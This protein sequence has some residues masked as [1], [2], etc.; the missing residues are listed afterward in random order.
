MVKV[1]QQLTIV[2]ATLDNLTNLYS[3]NN[4]VIFEEKAN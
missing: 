2:K 1:S 4:P 3:N